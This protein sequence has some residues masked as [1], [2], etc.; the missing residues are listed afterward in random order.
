MPFEL[1]PTL[2]GHC[3][4]PFPLP[5]PRMA[6]SSSPDLSEIRILFLSRH[7]KSCPPS[8]R[9]SPSRSGSPDCC[10]VRRVPILGSGVHCQHAWMSTGERPE[11]D[12]GLC[13]NSERCSPP[14]P[15][16][17]GGSCHP[18]LALSFKKETIQ[19][20]TVPSASCLPVGPTRTCT[21]MRKQRGAAGVR[22]RASQ[23]RRHGSQP[24]S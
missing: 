9:M 20:K 15:T 23:A 16:S 12:P 19:N 13:Y 7:I 8:P 6:R 17:A 2:W 22:R 24:R 10:G 18:C 11:K 21:L 1:T 3:P 5:L 14:L 4:L